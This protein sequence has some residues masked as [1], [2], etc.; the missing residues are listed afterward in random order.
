M[1]EELKKTLQEKIETN[2]VKSEMTWTKSNG[3]QVTEQV[4]LKRSRIP[5]VGDWAR[6]YPPLNEDGSWNIVNLIFGG[7]QNFWKLVG[8]M[9]IL[10][11]LWTW[12]TGMIGA[13]R[14][15]MT[16][17]YIIIKESLFNKYCTNIIYSTP[18]NP[19][20]GNDISKF[21]IEG[22]NQTVYK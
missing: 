19:T 10:F 18:D 6:V 11:L 2:A 5:L 17:E 7:K 12:T 15:Y 3:E 16:K 14:Q 13:D 9:F 8:I 4:Y 22:S 1:L 21:I 20:I